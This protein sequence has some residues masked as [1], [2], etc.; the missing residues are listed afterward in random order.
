MNDDMPYDKLLQGILPISA[1]AE[2]SKRKVLFLN[3]KYFP[4][5]YQHKRD[6]N[7]EEGEIRSKIA[8]SR[9]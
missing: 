9:K 6:K 1:D 8:T 3:E 7:F 5:H 2:M 4:I